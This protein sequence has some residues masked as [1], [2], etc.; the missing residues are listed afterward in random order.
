MSFDLCCRFHCGRNE[1]FL[2][3]WGHLGHDQ[4]IPTDPTRP[5]ML[6]AGIQ[7][8][9]A[10]PKWH[11]LLGYLLNPFVY[12]FFF[13]LVLS[14]FSKA[15]TVTCVYTSWVQRHLQPVAKHATSKLRD[16]VFVQAFAWSFFNDSCTQKAFKAIKTRTFRQTLPVLPAAALLNSVEICPKKFGPRIYVSFSQCFKIHHNSTFKRKLCK[17]SF[18]CVQLC[19]QGIQKTSISETNRIV[20]W[21]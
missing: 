6:T 13:L 5:T 19:S 4:K 21:E 10:A 2:K 7:Y 15:I 18:I 16:Q 17:M 12:P 9:R 11:L 3:G 14:V 1:D 20:G 8:A